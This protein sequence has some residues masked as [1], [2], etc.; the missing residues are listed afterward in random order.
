L[1]VAGPVGVKSMRFNVGTLSAPAAEQ[2]VP[3]QVL[4]Y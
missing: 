1:G 2:S 3:E 4:T